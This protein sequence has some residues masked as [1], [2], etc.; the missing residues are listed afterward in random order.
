MNFNPEI[1][2]KNG[3]DFGAMI[4][5]DFLNHFATAH[6]ELDNSIY[7]VVQHISNF[8]LKLDIKLDVN[9]PIKFDLSPISDQ[10]FLPIWKSHLIVK[11]AKKDVNT[12][13]IPPNL[14]IS[15][16]NVKFTFIVY[17]EDGSIDF[18]I[19]F[20]WDISGTCAIVLDSIED[21]RILRLEPIKIQFQKHDAELLKEINLRLQKLIPD[22]DNKKTGI[23]ATFGLMNSNDPEKLVLYLLNQILAT[24]VSNFIKEFTLPKAFELMKGV[25]IEPG[26]LSIDNKALSVGC[27]VGNNNSDLYKITESK[28]VV[29]MEEFTQEFTK[30]FTNFNED[31]LKEWSPERSTTIAWLNLQIDEIS[32]KKKH[33][34]MKMSIAEYPQNLILFTNDRLTDVIANQFFNF[35]KSADYSATLIPL[36]LKAKCGWSCK[37]SNSDTEILDHGIKLTMNSKLYGYAAVGAPNPDPK[38]W[39]E[40]IWLNLGVTVMADPNLGVIAYPKFKEN[41]IYLSGELTTKCIKANLDGVPSWANSAI[42]WITSLITTPLFTAI[43]LIAS[44]FDFKII[45]YPSPGFPG[46]AIIIKPENWRINQ[47]P[48]KLGSYLVFS[49]DTQFQ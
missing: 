31:K 38:H 12:P 17:K 2:E 44:S 23:K 7:H 32:K 18:P 34:L 26:Y 35:N 22:K 3:I 37:L 47:S 40:W 1:F 14:K 29:F 19:E 10:K 20:F 24:Q 49:G 39:G 8:G 15:A 16:N 13:I 21:E 33:G 30:E 41:G 5:E 36:V 42:G 46:T 4:S 11:G 45:D 9:N 28:F 43:N 6:H 48:L 27:K 25:E